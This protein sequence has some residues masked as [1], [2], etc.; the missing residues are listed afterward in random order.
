MKKRDLY[1]FNNSLLKISQWKKKRY[2]RVHIL[3]NYSIISTYAKFYNTF[4]YAPTSL[5]MASNI[6]YA[7]KHKKIELIPIIVNTFFF[8]WRRETYEYNNSLCKLASEKRMPYKIIE[9]ILIIVNTFFL[10]EERDLYENNN[11]LL[12]IDKWKEDVL[13]FI[14]SLVTWLSTYAKFY[15]TFSY[16]RTSLTMASNIRS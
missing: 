15:D 1:E 4:S 7:N 14:F 9:L 8:L 11:S 13:R 16:S 10:M 3:T 2:L 5:I 6:N 12:K